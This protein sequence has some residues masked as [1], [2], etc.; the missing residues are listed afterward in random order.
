M[1]HLLLQQPGGRRRLS[2]RALHD[3]LIVDLEHQP[4]FRQLCFQP[5][6]GRHHGQLHDVRRRALDG[7]VQRHPLTE[8]A[9]VVV[10]GGQ[11][12]QI[13]AP[14][15]NGLHISGLPG[16]FHHSVHIA[17][18]T[19]ER[20]E[21]RLHI[22]LGLRHGDADVLAERKGGD[23]VYDSEIH[24]LGAA[25][26]LRCHVRRGHMEHLG[27]RGGVDIAAGA[28]GRPHS[29]VPGDMGQ[30]PQLDL[31]VVRVHQ[32]AALVRHEHSANFAAQVR[33]GGDIL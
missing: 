24:R 10:G 13:P 27:R 1:L 23:A 3:E 6:V 16:L 25:A 21:I 26:H 14:V 32:D 28:K 9:E 7:H 15:E 8:G 18:H 29:L 19:G 11:L 4:G 17:A 2:L 31:G 5:L 33:A 22:R 12:R 20:G 30:E